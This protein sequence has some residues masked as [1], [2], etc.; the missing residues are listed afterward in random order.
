M[1]LYEYYIIF[2]EGEKQE[3]LHSL[4]IGTLIDINGNVLSQRLTTNKIIAYQIASK[5][6]FEE[7]GIVQTVY[8]LEQLSSDELLDYI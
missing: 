8:M 2:P 3:I 4:P 7:R 6:T 5:R 1:T